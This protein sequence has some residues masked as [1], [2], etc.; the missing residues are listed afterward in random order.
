VHQAFAKVESKW[1]LLGLFSV[2]FA[3]L[4]LLNL[5]VFR[6]YAFPDSHDTLAHVGFTLD[7]ME[8]GHLSSI[9]IYPV[10]HLWLTGIS[11]VTQLSQQMG[12]SIF[13]SSI[14]LLFLL[15]IYLLARRISGSH[16]SGLLALAFASPPIFYMLL[17]VTLPFG[18]SLLLFPLLLYIFHSGKL[19]SIAY[20]ILFLF[21]CFLLTY[22][23]PITPLFIIA[24]LVTF[25]LY[26]LLS[27]WNHST[28]VRP[29]VVIAF[30][31]WMLL[32]F[33]TLMCFYTWYLSFASVQSDLKS[34]IESVVA[35][36]NLSPAEVT[37]SSVQQYGFSL[38]QLVKIYIF[39]FGI[40]TLYII[41]A[42]FCT[43][44]TLFKIIRQRHKELVKNP[45]NLAYILQ[46]FVSLFISAVFTFIFRSMFESQRSLMSPT[47][48][49]IIVI[50]LVYYPLL[51]QVIYLQS[52]YKIIRNFVVAIVLINATIIGVFGYFP[53][54]NI[55]LNNYQATYSQIAG[56]SWTVRYTN[57]VIIAGQPMIRH[58]IF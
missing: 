17:L 19:N 29:K 18:L 21:M 22:F 27:N 58:Q 42:L 40:M 25:G 7:I 39:R 43:S 31:N 11:L 34:V 50:G 45:M 12:I 54:P 8:T 55:L 53:S 36:F 57:G 3:N 9:D 48:F 26:S 35:G 33:I 4:I 10:T 20:T 2:I 16:G 41:L 14:Y 44:L 37:I 46:L 49:A 24:I 6:G 38:S 23:H 13:V 1:W 47:L 30:P 15:G 28:S 32:T 52:K 56:A 51:T 5:P